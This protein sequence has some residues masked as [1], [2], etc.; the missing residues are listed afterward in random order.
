MD[1]RWGESE[2]AAGVN[3]TDMAIDDDDDDD[4]DA[5]AADGARAIGGGGADEIRAARGG[6]DAAAL[7]DA[8]LVPAA[9]SSDVCMLH[10]CSGRICATSPRTAKKDEGS[11]EGAM[12]RKGR[13]GARERWRSC[14][15]HKGRTSLSA[16]GKTRNHSNRQCPSPLFLYTLP[17]AP[18]PKPVQL[19]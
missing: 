9:C 17:L 5:V 8:G 6:A 2:A 16:E 4:A 15:T 1:S 3:S 12:G 10:C 19:R 7:E 13:Q 14:A 18:S 11:E